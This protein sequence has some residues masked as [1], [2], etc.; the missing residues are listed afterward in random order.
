MM[1]SGASGFPVLKS[2][3][4]NGWNGIGARELT[5]ICCASTWTVADAPPGF[6]GAI[7]AA[8]TGTAAT[9]IWAARAAERV[10]PNAICF[11]EWSSWSLVLTLTPILEAG[12]DYI[13]EAAQPL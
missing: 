5:W 13:P 12:G 10:R 1:V 3:S 11:I 2:A 8:R 7:A 9:E 6:A 4:G